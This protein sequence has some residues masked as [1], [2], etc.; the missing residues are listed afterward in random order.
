MRHYE[1]VQFIS[2][3][4]SVNQT[5]RFPATSRGL[6]ENMDQIVRVS[7]RGLGHFSSSSQLCFCQ[8]KI[9][10]LI[11]LCVRP[12]QDYVNLILY[13]ML[14]TACWYG[15]AIYCFADAVGLGGLGSLG[16]KNGNCFKKSSVLSIVVF[17][18]LARHVHCLARVGVHGVLYSLSGKSCLQYI[19][20]ATL[21][22]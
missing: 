4:R 3:R 7:P 8:L 9:I 1:Q 6:L 16:N 15:N 18:V 11:R 21:N 14:F 10:H 20:F 13:K 22:F 19:K 2:A 17:V 12:A 5:S